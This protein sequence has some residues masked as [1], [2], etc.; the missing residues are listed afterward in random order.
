MKKH[1]FLI[2]FL[3]CSSV[4]VFG[5]NDNSSTN[6]SDKSLKV[7][8]TTNNPEGLIAFP[9]T[10]FTI[11]Q[12][13]TMYIHMMVNYNKQPDIAIRID[14]QNVNSDGTSATY[15]RPIAPYT[16]YNKWENLVFPISGGSTGKEV[17][18]ILI[19]PDLGIENQPAGQI[20][21]DTGNFGY[22]DEII[23][24][25]NT[26]LS[27]ETIF[28][29]NKDLSIF[30]NPASGKIKISTE[31]TI[32]KILLYT[33]LGKEITKRIHKINTNEYDLTGLSSG[34]YFIKIID[35]NGSNYKR[36]IIKQ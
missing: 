36:K 7:W 10:N 31:M 27:T 24:S 33:S 35:E 14:A 9:V 2:L 21:N 1:K 13:T 17:N 5:Q 15:I 34:I 12:N 25:Q 22:I 6:T 32:V 28:N 16:S 30:P 20:L 8:R 11:P 18:T 23:L 4:F 26:T 29:K 3:I 19:F